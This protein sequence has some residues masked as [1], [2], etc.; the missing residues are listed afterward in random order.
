[1][2]LRKTSPAH[3]RQRFTAPEFSA[4]YAVPPRAS[5]PQRSGRRH[6]RAN[7]ANIPE[8]G[9]GPFCGQPPEWNP[10]F[11]IRPSPAGTYGTRRRTG[12]KFRTGPNR[13]QA[14]YSAGEGQ[15]NGTPAS[16]RKPHGRSGECSDSRHE[17]YRRKRKPR[18]APF[19]RPPRQGVPKAR[20]TKTARKPGNTPCPRRKQAGEGQRNGTPASA[21]KPHGRSGEC[22]DSRHEPYRRKRKPRPAPFFRPPRQGVPKARGAGENRPKTR[23]HPQSSPRTKPETKPGPREQ[24]PGTLRPNPCDRA[25][26]LFA[27]TP[28]HTFAR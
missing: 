19:F 12:H 27:R 1:M 14:A 21:R 17:P 9:S 20:G 26:F 15:R 13:R 25:P 5:A 7:A 6:L 24:L 4:P 18:P 3:P 22:S 16:A 11:R 28:P 2:L 10:S 23:E 8:G